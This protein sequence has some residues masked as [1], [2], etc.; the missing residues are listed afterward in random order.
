MGKRLDATARQNVANAARKCM[1]DPRVKEHHRRETLK[2]MQDPGV[3]ARTKQAALR[4]WQDPDYRQ[5]QLA[6]HDSPM[7]HLRHKARTEGR[8]KWLASMT[9][10]E[11]DNFKVEL[12]KRAANKQYRAFHPDGSTSDISN[13]KQ[14]CRE[15]GISYD[16]AIGLLS[17]RGRTASGYTFQ[18]LPQ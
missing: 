8:N 5:K 12:A 7:A 3:R 16:T 10:A 4:R 17:G 9:P 2:A 13:L 1:S 6:Q 14:F 18:R 15:K 11:Y